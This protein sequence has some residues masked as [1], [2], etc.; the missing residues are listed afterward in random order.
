MNLTATGKF[1]MVILGLAGL[2]VTAG[3]LSMINW[4]SRD[5]HLKSQRRN[6]RLVNLP[7]GRPA[8]A[9]VITSES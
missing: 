5:F 2:I 9:P 8:V 7:Q 1:I 3:A 6:I 4:R